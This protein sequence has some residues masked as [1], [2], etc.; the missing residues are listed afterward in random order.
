MSAVEQIKTGI[1]WW[2]REEVRNSHEGRNKPLDDFA[3]MR[4]GYLF[5]ALDSRNT[6]AKKVGGHIQRYNQ[7]I[8]LLNENKIREDDKFVGKMMLFSLMF[9]SGGFRT[10]CFMRAANQQQYMALRFDHLDQPNSATSIPIDQVANEAQDNWETFTAYKA[11]NKILCDLIWESKN[12][13]YEWF[14]DNPNRSMDAFK[15]YERPVE[16]ARV[17]QEAG[18]T[19]AISHIAVVSAM[20]GVNVAEVPFIQPMSISDADKQPLIYP[21]SPNFNPSVVS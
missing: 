5:P 7:A 2:L 10:E 18:L 15:E 12:K 3:W 16:L 9:V 8:D 17:M 6:D 1:D 19:L 11:T 21:L 20:R 14:R 4:S 13:T